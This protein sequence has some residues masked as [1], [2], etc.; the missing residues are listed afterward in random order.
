MN[1][2]TPLIAAD[3]PPREKPSS[4]PEPFASLLAGRQ[5]QA[6]G[7]AFGLANFGINRTVLK[8]GAASALRHWHTVQDEFIYI[9]EGHPTLITDSGETE[10]APGMCMGF[11][12]GVPDGHQLVNRSNGDVIYLEVGDQLPGDSG[13][14]PDDDLKAVM[15]DDGKWCFMHK[16]GSPY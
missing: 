15:G 2:P 1:N 9:L 14:Y 6:L 7:D 16:D 8:P 13:R 12:A 10:L 5:K 11:K 4:Y 3:I